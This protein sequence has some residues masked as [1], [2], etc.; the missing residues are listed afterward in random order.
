[1]V[2]QFD[3]ALLS[4]LSCLSMK[5]SWWG[6]CVIMYAWSFCTCTLGI[7]QD[8]APYT[9][10]ASTVALYTLCYTRTDTCRLF[11][12]LFLNFP[13]ITL[14]LLILRESSSSSL[15]FSETTLPRYLK[16]VY[17]TSG[18]VLMLIS[19]GSDVDNLN[20]GGSSWWR[21][22]VFLMLILRLDWLVALTNF[23]TKMACLPHCV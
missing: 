20:F 16:V 2:D 5:G 10:V 8:S 21:H 22:S 9:R 19:S 17:L 23:S 12:S 18:S 3:P 4:W 11:H 6:R 1:M 15:E 13:Y 7:V 14:P